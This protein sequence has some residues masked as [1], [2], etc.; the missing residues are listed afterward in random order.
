MVEFSWVNDNTRRDKSMNSMATLG[1]QQWSPDQKVVIDYLA[2]ISKDTGLTASEIARKAGISASTLTRIFPNPKVSYS[3][4]RRTLL[5]INQAFP[6]ICA[7]RDWA[8]PH[9]NATQFTS[10]LDAMPGLANELT[11]LFSLTPLSLANTANE[12]LRKIQDELG[13]ELAHG[14]LQLP[15]AYISIPATTHRHQNL[16][17]TYIPG[18]GMEP[19]YRAGEIVIASLLKPAGIRTDV[20]V[21]ISV[22]TDCPK[23]EKCVLYCVAQLIS[24]TSNSITLWQHKTHK[25]AEI[26]I[27]DLSFV[28]S[29]VALLEE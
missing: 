5:K 1:D 18:D 7:P 6:H 27:S 16:I 14:N 10:K 26:A 19:R 11:P 25:Q 24:R 15:C 20:L 3:L 9:E 21:G 17:A 4:S 2:K 23:T 8:N 22:G 13:L 12:R 29:I 28:Y